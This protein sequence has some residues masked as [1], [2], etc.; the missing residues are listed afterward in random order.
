M[1]TSTTLTARRLLASIVA[2]KRVWLPFAAAL[3]CMLA[4]R[5]L[6]PLAGFVAILVAVGLLLDG[7][8]VLFARGANLKDYRQ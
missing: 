8:T 7:V 1:P 6:G 5:M 3:L 4:S 2:A